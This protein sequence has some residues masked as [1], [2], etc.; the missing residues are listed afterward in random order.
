[1]LEGMTALGFMAAHTSRARLGPDG[2]RRPLPPARRCGSRRR[3]R[4][5][6]CPAAAPGSGSARPGTRRSPTGSG[7]RSR[8]SASASSCSR[9]R[10]GSPT[11]C[12]A[13]SAAAAAASRDARS[14]PTRLLNSP[15]SLSRPRIPIMIGGGGEQKT[16]RLVAQYADAHERV[17][18]TAAIAHKYAVLREHCDRLGR[19]YEEIERSRR[20]SAWTSRRGRPSRR[21]SPRPA[22]GPARRTVRR[23]RPARHRHAGPGGGT[24]RAERHRAR[25]PASSAGP[26]GDRRAYS[27]GVSLGAIISGVM[28]NERPTAAPPSNRLSNLT[29]DFGAASPAN[30][31]G[32]ATGPAG[33]QS[34]STA[35]SFGGP[36]AILGD[37]GPAATTGGPGSQ[38]L[39]GARVDAK[40]VIVGS[41][42]AGLTAAIYAARADLAPV[43]LAGSTA[44]RPA[45]AHDRGRELP[46]L[47]RRASRAR[48]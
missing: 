6:S 38:P 10:S 43:V 3:R 4:S 20:S 44:G 37:A 33:G 21:Q 35:I 9:T 45:D 48:T 7:S 25:R 27:P 47:P 40:V 22:R 15:Q 34:A 23:R 8:R 18:R 12:G 24:H 36:I 29:I 17:R 11:R 32:D 16:L 2:R 28:T 5:T 1:M 46:G 19:P 31:V 39:G 42:P 14:T 26:L 30:A 41:G 13:A